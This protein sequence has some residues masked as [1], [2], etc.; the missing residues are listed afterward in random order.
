MG[1]KTK[2]IMIETCDFMTDFVGK[3]PNMFG[4]GN[5]HMSMG[6]T[7]WT[8]THDK[9]SHR[10]ELEFWAARRAKYEAA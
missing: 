4:P 7:V 6:Q 9:A 2:K 3:N 1:P 8:P 10:R 5:P